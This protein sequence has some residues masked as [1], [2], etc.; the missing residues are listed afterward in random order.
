MR[1]RCRDLGII[2]TMMRLVTAYP[3]CPAYMGF[4]NNLSRSP[5]LHLALQVS[6]VSGTPCH[7][8]HHHAECACAPPLPTRT[9]PHTRACVEMRVPICVVRRA[10]ES[11]VLHAMR[12]VLQSTCVEVNRV[13]ALITVAHV[14][15]GECAAPG[16][17]RALG[18]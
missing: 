5:A 6:R 2:P 3:D 7:E 12:H 15:A 9:H 4:V 14:F 17:Y 16:A 10:Q 13:Q 1:E 11:G 8:A 18:I